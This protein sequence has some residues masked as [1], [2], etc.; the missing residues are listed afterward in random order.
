MISVE[1]VEWLARE[2]HEGQVDKIGVPYFDHVRA[3]ADGLAPFGAEME[4]AGLLHD[5]VEDTPWTLDELRTAGI[6]ESVL[7]VVD[8]VTNRPGEDY[9]GRLERI[10]W[11]W[12]ACRVKISDNAHNSRADRAAFLE[13]KQRER[14]SRKYQKARQT[15]WAGAS[16]GDVRTIL[17]IVNP[18]LLEELGPG[19]G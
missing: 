1:E 13:A 14:L 6:P 16:P 10:S 17:T 2:A 7:E 9:Q 15:L 8:A 12:R 5:I 19:S 4:M 18:D 3:V 11:H